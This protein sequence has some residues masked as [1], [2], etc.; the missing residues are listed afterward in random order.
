MYCTGCGSQLREGLRFCPVCGTSLEGARQVQGTAAEPVMR[1]VASQPGHT[2][3]QQPYQP[4]APTVSAPEGRGKSRKLGIVLA[5]LA[6]L[7]VGAVI[8]LAAVFMTRGGQGIKSLFSGAAEPRDL[9]VRVSAEGL[10]KNG[11]R[12]PVRITGTQDDGVKIDLD[13]YVGPGSDPLSVYPGTYK[14]KVLG[15]PISADGVIY[16][17]EDVSCKVVVKDLGAGAKARKTRKLV[18]TP[19]AAADMTKEQVSEAREWAQADPEREDVADDLASAAVERH[20]NAGSEG[21]TGTSPDSSSGAV[22]GYS[23][24]SEQDNAQQQAE[25]LEAERAQLRADAEARGQ[26]VFTGVVEVMGGE[27]VCAISGVP[28]TANG[29]SVAARWREAT[30]VLLRLDGVHSAYIN[31]RAAED[32]YTTECSYVG[33]GR[34]D[35]TYE[36]ASPGLDVW[37]SRDGM[38]VCVAAYD[39]SASQ[40]VDLFGPWL[41]DAELLY[42]LDA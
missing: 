5:A 16:D 28:I 37:V 6:G 23:A 12:V 29:E 1:H 36:S 41:D 10:D 32:N 24:E 30:Y 22:A 34:S 8:L 2:A 25:D 9:V 31:T 40:G 17:Y 21:G 27:G 14:V 7:A 15:S 42:E 20:N 18:L 19:I 11:S 38:H 26:Q 35:Y 4:V 3:Q 33:L 13:T 39:I